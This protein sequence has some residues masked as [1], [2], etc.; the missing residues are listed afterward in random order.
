MEVYERAEALPAIPKRRVHV[1]EGES[2]TNSVARLYEAVTLSSSSTEAERV[3]V[4]V[5][6]ISREPGRLVVRGSAAFNLW[7]Q[8]ECQGAEA[9]LDV[10]E[11]AARE[12]NPELLERLSES[13]EGWSVEG[14]A[15]R[16]LFRDGECVLK[17]SSVVVRLIARLLS[18]RLGRLRRAA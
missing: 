15:V 3:N 12:K 18:E 17:G 8:L 11:R 7:A 16:L 14:G 4:E 9:L 5:R 6:V 10:L 13:L 2:R 1:G